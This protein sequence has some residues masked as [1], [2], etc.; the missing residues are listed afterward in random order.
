LTDR[1]THRDSR[2]ARGGEEGRPTTAH[3]LTGFFLAGLVAR[4]A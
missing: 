3:F 4:L 1:A 2:L